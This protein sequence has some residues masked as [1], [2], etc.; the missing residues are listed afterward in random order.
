[1]SALVPDR[2]ADSVPTA[3]KPVSTP[4]EPQASDI[5]TAARNAL[6]L[7][8]SLLATWTVALAVRFQLPRHLGPVEFGNF[9]FCDSFSAAFFVF[10]GLG[11]ETYIQKEVPIR[12]Q[13]ASDFFG[14]VLV[15][16][17]GLS[18]IVLATMATVL[19]LTGRP[20]ELQL[21][22]LVFGLTQATIGFNLSIAA[23]LQ[24]S[25]KV[26]PLAA[27]NVVSKLLWG[28]GVVVGIWLDAPLPLLALPNLVAELLKASVLYPTARAA[29]GLRL[30]FA[31]GPLKTVLLASLPFY[32][33]TIAINLGARLDVSM[34]EFLAPGEEVGWYSAASNFAGLA[35]LFSPVVNWVLMPLF[36]RAKHRSEES[37]YQ[38]LRR[39]IEGLLVLAVPVTLLIGLGADFWVRLAFG[40]SFGPAAMSLRCLA[41]LFVA[42][43]LALMLALA[44]VVLERSWRLTIVSLIGLGVL[45]L[46]ILVLVPLAKPLGVGMAGAGAAVGVTAMELMTAGLFLQTVGRRAL[47]TR[48]VLAIVKSMGVA[49]VVIALHQALA[50]MGHWRLIVDMFAYAVL[51]LALKVVRLNEAINVIKTV[52]SE[53][54]AAKAGV[55]VPHP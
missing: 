34:L 29:V 26:G 28:V 7:G 38:M 5:A 11:V 53:R 27:M 4:P 31:M 36:A 54:K 9:N 13:H 44:L 37:F 30:H 23:M 35:M 18:V 16:R 24:A 40:R 47:D 46:L 14:G 39:A 48:N 33:N 55:A 51:A 50:F 10:L 1:M 49:A 52:R 6:K 2:P 21:T 3:P 19:A 17:A 15:V 41:P 43:Y 25:T 22:V 45:P 32:V 12:P 20:H 42:T 8:G